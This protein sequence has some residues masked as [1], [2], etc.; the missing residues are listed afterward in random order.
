MQDG[1]EHSGRVALVTGASDGMGRAVVLGL[2]ARGAIVVAVAR[3]EEKL[4][5]LARDAD[6]QSNGTG[7]VVPA[8]ADLSNAEGCAEA[9]R[10][11]EGV[12]P[13]QILVNNVG[14]SESRPFHRADDDEWHRAIEL[15]LMAAVRITRGCLPAMR[16]RRWGRIVSVASLAARQPDPF[17]PA[18][19]AAKA[20]LLSL[21]KSLAGAYAK[22]GVTSNCVLPGFTDT[23]LMR[24]SIAAAAEKAHT[25]PQAVLDALL[26][27]DGVPAGRLGTPEDVAGAVLYL[28][29]DAASLVTGATLSVDGGQ[30]RST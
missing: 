19:S 12:G 26:A 7:R 9:L 4:A 14:W 22:D 28:V 23:A 24:D 25:T 1:G 5:Q 15:N 30:L 11:A 27:R 2:A 13:V 29:S 21:S 6:A 10:V 8:R 16:E 3:G 17:L 20:A 18:Y